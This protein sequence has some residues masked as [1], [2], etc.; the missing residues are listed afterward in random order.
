MSENYYEL[1][2]INHKKNISSLFSRDIF[3]HFLEF[4]YSSDNQK[5]E[6]YFFEIFWKMGND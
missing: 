4:G 6:I 1:H 5:M 3:Q 2:S